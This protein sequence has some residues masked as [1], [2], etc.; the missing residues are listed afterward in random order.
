MRRFCQRDDKL[1]ILNQI[2]KPR[3]VTTVCLQA[4][5]RYD[6][7]QFTDAELVRSRSLR[8]SCFVVQLYLL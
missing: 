8:L 1:L 3:V 6:P 7:K 2:K 4:A 5:L